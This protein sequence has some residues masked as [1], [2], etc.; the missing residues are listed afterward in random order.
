MPL[1]VEIFAKGMMRVSA[2]NVRAGSLRLDVYAKPSTQ[3]GAQR[4]FDTFLEARPLLLD[5]RSVLY[6]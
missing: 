5:Y 3:S 4:M 2:D 6:A 1:V